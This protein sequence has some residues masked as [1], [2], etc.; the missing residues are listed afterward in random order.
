[1]EGASCAARLFAAML[2]GVLDD[3]GVIL[4][5][6]L[7]IRGQVLHEEGADILVSFFSGDKAEA[8]QKPPGIG[9]HH[10]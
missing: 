1:M 10:E 8:G 2:L 6:E 9:I 3:Q 7:H 4:V 5:E